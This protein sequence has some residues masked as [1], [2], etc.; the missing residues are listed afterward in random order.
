VARPVFCRLGCAF[1]RQRT[2]RNE[3]DPDHR[4]KLPRNGAAPYYGPVLRERK[5]ERFRQFDLAVKLDLGASRRN[6]AQSAWRYS[7]AA[8]AVDH[9][10]LIYWL[11]L[12]SGLHFRR[13]G[14]HFQLAI[15][16]VKLL[17][18][19]PLAKLLRFR[20]AISRVERDPAS[21]PG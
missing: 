5:Q 10:V 16:Y 21:T 11:T 8:G 19:A 14:T 18:L 2:I 17:M 6:V 7:S 3:L 15:A 12:G 20:E 4:R 1:S 13:P 9:A